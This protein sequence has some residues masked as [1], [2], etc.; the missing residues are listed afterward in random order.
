MVGGTEGGQMTEPIAA[1]TPVKILNANYRRSWG[2]E[3]RGPFGPNGS[4]V[5]SVLVAK[6]PRRVY[7]E[8]REDQLQ[9]VE[10]E[11]AC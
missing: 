9:V 3:Y 10:E 4:R 11:K 8:V 1:G 2:A 5:Y 7:V 6:K